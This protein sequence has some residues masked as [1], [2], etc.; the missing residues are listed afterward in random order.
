MRKSVLDQFDL[1]YDENM[2][3][4]EDYDFWIRIARYG[5][6]ANIGERLLLY[7][8]HYKQESF[9]KKEL[10]DLKSEQC[11]LK[12][13]QQVNSI[14]ERKNFSYNP[15]ES[16]TLNDIINQLLRVQSEW[17]ELSNRNK[18]VKYYDIVL[19]KNYTRLKAANIIRSYFLSR[20][21]KNYKTA[22]IFLWRGTS[23]FKYFNKKEIIK[24]ALSGLYN[25]FKSFLVK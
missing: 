14:I 6:L 17:E 2:D 7:R 20:E 4:A 12:G 21:N 10:Q 22:T 13:L 18:L 15:N 5:K 24:I 9:V 3:P 16:D 1:R 19:F 11:Q 8:I 25:S 23:F